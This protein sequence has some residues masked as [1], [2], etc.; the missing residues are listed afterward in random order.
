MHVCNDAF[1]SADAAFSKFVD[2][3]LTGR[4]PRHSDDAAGTDI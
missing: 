1:L 4:D 3:I 2:Q